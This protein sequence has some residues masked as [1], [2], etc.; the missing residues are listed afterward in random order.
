[1]IRSERNR[2][3][4]RDCYSKG[5]AT[6]TFGIGTRDDDQPAVWTLTDAISRGEHG[7]AVTRNYRI[8]NHHKNGGMF[9]NEL[10][11]TP[12]YDSTGS[13]VHYVGVQNDI[14]ERIRLNETLERRDQRHRFVTTGTTYGRPLSTRSRPLR[15]GP[16]LLT[17]SS[18][19][20][21][22]SGFPLPDTIFPYCH[23]HDS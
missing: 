17:V 5:I 10:Y 16:F 2:K 8:R 11:L 3:H 9:W 14:T 1:M 13:L 20:I 7:G 12:V 15:F 21:E 18:V 22:R 4:K 19:R 23:A 6:K